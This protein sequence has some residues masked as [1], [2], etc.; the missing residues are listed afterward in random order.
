MNLE[1]DFDDV[2]LFLVDEVRGVRFTRKKESEVVV[3]RPVGE[4]RV[5]RSEC[6]ILDFIIRHRFSE[7]FPRSDLHHFRALK[8]NLHI[9][10][11]P[12]DFIEIRLFLFRP[13]GHDDV[14]KIRI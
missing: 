12:V 13:I 5:R 7:A 9:G 14:A 8:K 1:H 2:L 4:D 6:G 11:L 10:F 3:I